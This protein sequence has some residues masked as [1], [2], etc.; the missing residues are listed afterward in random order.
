MPRR[1]GNRTNSLLLC[2]MFLLT[3]TPQNSKFMKYS[4]KIIK[5][6]ISDKTI[7]KQTK[8]QVK[9]GPEGEQLVFSLKVC[10][11]SKIP[12]EQREPAAKAASESNLGASDKDRL[13]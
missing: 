13:M 9:L 12:L 7:K 8:E 5:L 11:G 2:I 3:E 1:E 6:F 4:R 10:F